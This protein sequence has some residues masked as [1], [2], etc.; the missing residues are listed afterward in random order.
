MFCVCC[1]GT[2]LSPPPDPPQC[3]QQQIYSGRAALSWYAGY[4]GPW[5]SLQ[6]PNMSASTQ[7]RDGVLGSMAES[8]VSV[9]E[10]G[11]YLK[12]CG[13]SRSKC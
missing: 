4:V 13:G 5:L 11:P 7:P 2:T 9:E 6:S 1:W 8:E 3:R 10:V 12:S